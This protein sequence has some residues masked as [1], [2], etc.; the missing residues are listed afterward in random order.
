M[1]ECCLT[2][3]LNHILVHSKCC[4]QCCC[5]IS[6]IR[7]MAKSIMILRINSCRQRINRWLILPINMFAVRC[8]FIFIVTEHRI[9]DLYAIFSTM[10]H[11]IHRKIH[12]FHQLFNIFCSIW[13]ST[14]SCTDCDCLQ[15][16][17]CSAIIH[18]K[19]LFRNRFHQISGR[20]K[21]ISRQ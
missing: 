8:V 9:K 4:C 20:E 18:N 16:H 13:C 19:N 14:D 2:D 7:G 12:I 15:F 1:Q 21:V 6:H 17:I 5:I 10:F 3:D 11:M